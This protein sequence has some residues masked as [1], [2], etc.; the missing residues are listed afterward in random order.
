M[1]MIMEL[2]II[3]VII[4]M[5]INIH[6]GSFQGSGVGPMTQGANKLPCTSGGSG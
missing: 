4:M 1:M 5:T 2:I 3:V 6:F